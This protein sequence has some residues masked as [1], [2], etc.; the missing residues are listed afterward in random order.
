MWKVTDVYFVQGTFPK[1]GTSRIP[2]A[3]SLT[4]SLRPTQKASLGT[5]IEDALDSKT[6]D[7]L[8][9]TLPKAEK[10]DTL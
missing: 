7:E 9:S 10:E 8:W 5:I 2:E 1:H 4:T 6:T 3:A